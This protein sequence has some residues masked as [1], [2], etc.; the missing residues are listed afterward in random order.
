MNRVSKADLDVNLFEDSVAMRRRANFAR[1]AV[2]AEFRERDARAVT[3]AYCE[4]KDRRPDEQWCDV[5]P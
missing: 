1:S 4:F 5:M 3:R 2:F